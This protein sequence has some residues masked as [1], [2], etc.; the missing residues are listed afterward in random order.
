MANILFP[1]A[2]NA[3]YKV[4]NIKSYT[5]FGYVVDGHSVIDLSLGG[6]G[7]FMLGFT[8][9]EIVEYVA[10]RMVSNPFVCGEYYTTNDA[11]LELSDKLY[12]Q[13]G[14]KSFFS[15][16]GSDAIESAIK[17]SG[18]YFNNNTK[19]NIIGIRGAYHGSTFLASGIG[20]LDYMVAANGKSSRCIAIDFTNED[21][22]LNNVEQQPSEKTAAIVIES[23]SWSIGLITYS[24][25]FWKRLR[26]ICDEKDILLI[27]DDIAMC[28]GKTG[29]YFGFDLNIK[30]DMFCVGKA[31]SGGYFPL[32]A[33][34]FSDR[35]YDR[36]KDSMFAHGFTHSFSMSGIYA[37]LKQIEL[38]DMHINNYENIKQQSDNLFNKLGLP[39]K[40]Y[41]LVYYIDMGVTSPKMEE[42][43]FGN[44]LSVGL[45]NGHNSTVFVIVPLLA[46]SDYFTRL[47]SG[48]SKTS[49]DLSQSE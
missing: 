2:E 45:W 39:Y 38:V 44:G 32:T 36:I 24:E 26:F 21:E 49:K 18:I 8:Q 31:F 35:V 23:C 5:D 19:R 16:S 30:P 40:S 12:Q 6:C 48:F 15:T 33:C 27:I 41:G 10:K 13:T 9:H 1:F 42:T 4:R 29:D 43:F 22:F 46:D 37:T 20:D 11:V 17:I 47:E 3:N 14:Y 28:G 34:M 25:S 7:C